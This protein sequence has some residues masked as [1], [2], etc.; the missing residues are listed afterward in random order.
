MARARQKKLRLHTKNGE[1]E[2]IRLMSH[3][4]LHWQ[5]W[6]FS[7]LYILAQLMYI[8]I[9][10]NKYH[11]IILHSNLWDIHSTFVIHWGNTSVGEGKRNYLFFIYILTLQCTQSETQ[12]LSWKEMKN[13]LR[14]RKY[15]VFHQFHCHE[16]NNVCLFAWKAV[17]KSLV[18]H[19]N[20]DYHFRICK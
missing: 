9:N 18:W 5:Q 4:F 13:N 10:K 17:H 3:L 7:P 14:K 20:A 11:V 2:K 12:A 15:Y 1:L 6:I 8:N 16:S 19:K